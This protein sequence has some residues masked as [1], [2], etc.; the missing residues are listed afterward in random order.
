MTTLNLTQ[1]DKEAY[2]AKQVSQ[3]DLA[4]QYGVGRTTVRRALKEAGLCCY[5]DYATPSERSLLE[6]LKTHNINSTNQLSQ[7]ITRGL[8]C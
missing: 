7:V 4:I 6:V 5:A 1:T 3:A 8:Q 2:K